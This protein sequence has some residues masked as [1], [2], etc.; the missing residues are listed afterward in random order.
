MSFLNN[1]HP[2]VICMK[3]KCKTVCSRAKRREK[4]VEKLLLRKRDPFCQ[5]VQ[6][7]STSWLESLTGSHPVWV[8]SKRWGG[9]IWLQW[10]NKCHFQMHFLRVPLAETLPRLEVNVSY[11]YPK[12]LRNLKH[13]HKHT[14]QE[15]RHIGSIYYSLSE[16]QI[17]E[18]PVVV[19]K[20][21]C[22]VWIVQQGP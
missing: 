2:P 20:G 5:I 17:G 3:D 6:A 4:E 16:W 19:H 1:S 7:N 12:K 8:S 22:A 10:A 13:T 21:V 18:H 11:S 14:E 15:E 9:S